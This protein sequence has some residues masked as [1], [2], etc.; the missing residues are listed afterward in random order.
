MA[1]QGPSDRAGLRRALLTSYPWLGAT[2]VGPRAVQAGECDRC[3]ERPRLLPTCGPVPFEALCRPCAA[4]LGSD[5]WC[6]GHA[7]E[8]RAAL[9]WAARLPD[10]WPVVVRLWWAAT[11][12]LRLELN[13]SGPPG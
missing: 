4:E 3:G 9:A 7:D 6:E 1:W 5:A 10:E 12:E 13:G 11:G 2:D 8:G